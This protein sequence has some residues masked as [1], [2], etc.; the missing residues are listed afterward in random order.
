MAELMEACYLPPGVNKETIFV[1][2]LLAEVSLLKT[3][4]PQLAPVA[5]YT[6][7][8]DCLESEAVH[9]CERLKEAGVPVVTKNYPEAEHGFSHYKEGSKEYRKHDV[10]DCW[11]R[12][13]E[14]LGNA[15]RDDNIGGKD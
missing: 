5:C 4:Q 10:E 12:I 11:A 3:L 1:A 8:M 15:I 7:G 6:A 14:Y 9:F 2:P 13:V